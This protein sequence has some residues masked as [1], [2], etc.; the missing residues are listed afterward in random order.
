M[1]SKKEK[2]MRTR[3]EREIEKKRN[4]QLN[5]RSIKVNDRRKK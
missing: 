5:R 1:H 2:K 4:V 3:K